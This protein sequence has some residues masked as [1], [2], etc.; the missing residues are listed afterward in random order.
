MTFRNDRFFSA[1]RR[2]FLGGLGATLAAPAILRAAEDKVLYVNSYGGPW[3]KAATEFLFEPFT[4]ETGIRIHPVSPVSFAKLSAQV[5]TGT[6]EFD[7]MTL[8]VGELIR[9]NKADL[10]DKLE[11]G[12]IHED[13]LWPDAVKLN[14]LASHAFSY[15][16]AYNKEALPKGGPQSWAEFW[17]VEAFPGARSLQ[18]YP[19][20]VLA[21]ALM[22]DGV[23]PQDLF[24]YDVDRAFKSLDRIKPHVRV[25]WSQSA[26]AMQLIR[27]QEI[28]GVGIS[29]NNA[30]A[31][32][33]E[34]AP[35]ERVWN[36]ALLDT[37]YWSVA[38]GTPRAEH[39]WRFAEFAVRPE[40][41]SKFAVSQNYGPINP[42]AFELIPAEIAENMPTWPEN[43]AKAITLKPDA[44]YDQADAISTR[45]E[46][47]L[48][49]Q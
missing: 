35:V 7:I 21:F 3:E 16:I 17:D 1:N 9:A 40:N 44:L 13:K 15:L 34:G 39:A 19:A 26:Q 29:H 38:K 46:Q 28:S 37:A 41:L 8:G 5:R 6:Y 33:K 10:L 45:F 30:Q 12:K 11:P 22:A 2:V 4:K 36:Q 31:L 27:D 20:R 18:N 42:A 25:W 32:I 49:S 24:P 47:W 23:A 14:G 43:L 48:A